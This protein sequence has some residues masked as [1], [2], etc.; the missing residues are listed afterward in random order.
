MKNILKPIALILLF[1]LCW[2]CRVIQVDAEKMK[3]DYTTEGFLDANYFQVIIKSS[4]DRNA[5]GL[6]AKRDSAVRK[7]KERINTHTLGMLAEYYI[8]SRIKEMGIKDRK[9]ILNM[10]GVYATLAEELNPYLRYG[11]TAYEYYEEDCSAVIVYRIFKL[12]LQKDI[13]SIKVDM[14]LKGMEII[15]KK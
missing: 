12:G 1:S 15:P 3:T 4:P 6:V 9:E 11:S 7:A 14:L 8:V 5:K 10:D 13:E 2:S